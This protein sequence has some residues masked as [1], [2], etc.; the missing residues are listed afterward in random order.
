MD[1]L[2]IIILCFFKTVTSCSSNPVTAVDDKKNE[3]I[4]KLMMLRKKNLEVRNQESSVTP[5]SDSADNEKTKICSQPVVVTSVPLPSPPTSTK[6]VTPAVEKVPVVRDR[7]LYEK[8]RAFYVKVDRKPEV[9]EAR[10]QLPVC[11]MEQ[12]IM[13]AITENDVVIICGETGSGKTTQVPQFLFEAGY[14]IKGSRHEGMVGVTQPRRV[15]A[16]KLL[17]WCKVLQFLL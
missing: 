4:E 1:L 2:I 6:E 3:M 9:Q 5:V 15:A 17:F 7:S 10:M 16:G 12:E 14:G 13:E 8:E 11:G